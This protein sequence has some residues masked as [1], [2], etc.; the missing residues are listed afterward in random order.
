MKLYHGSNIIVETPKILEPV[1]SLDFGA[2]FYLTTD[3]E[4]A[5]KWSILKTERSGIG[6]PTVSVY[7][8]LEEDMKKLCILKFDSANKNWLEFVSM[9]RKNEI[10]EENSDIIIGPVANDNTM[11][12]IT[13]YLRGDYDVN[14]ALKRLLPQKL[15]DQIVFKNEKSLSYLKFVEVINI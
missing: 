15:K 8:I 9:N 13:L 6:R 5:K 14:E 11:P 12:V 3:F 4:Q 7:E 10:I 2:G 1:R